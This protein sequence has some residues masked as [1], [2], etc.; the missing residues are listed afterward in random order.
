MA[1]AS[2]RSIKKDKCKIM[3]IPETEKQ[4]NDFVASFKKKIDATLEKGSLT[5]SIDKLAD[6]LSNDL[7]KIVHCLNAKTSNKKNILLRQI[8]KFRSVIEDTNKNTTDTKDRIQPRIGVFTKKLDEFNDELVKLDYP[9]Y[10]ITKLIQYIQ[11]KGNKLITKYT[12]IKHNDDKEV[13]PHISLNSYDHI[14][15]I[16]N[17]TKYVGGKRRKTHRI[18]KHKRSNKNTYRKRTGKRTRKRTRKH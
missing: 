1:S 14:F 11:D 18:R 2:R 4:V 17:Y 7:F 3:N 13:I 8:K 5:N 6:Y 16:K 15:N 9:D 10:K 12:K